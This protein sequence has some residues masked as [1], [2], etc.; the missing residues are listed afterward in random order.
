MDDGDDR[1]A[2]GLAHL[3]TAARE[4]IAAARAF[5]DA[6]EDL[7]GDPAVAA[8]VVDALGSVVREAVRRAGGA[9][10][11]TAGA[12]DVDGAGGAAGDGGGGVE[13]VRVS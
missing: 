6:A 10:G 2:E 1:V 5:L 12:A 13:R 3:Q 8:A 9:A 11:G 7:I 4:A